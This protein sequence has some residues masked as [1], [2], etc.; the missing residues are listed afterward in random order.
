[1]EKLFLFQKFSFTL[2]P[3]NAQ[4]N[5]RFKEDEQG[6]MRCSKAKKQFA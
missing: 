6:L 4:E 1:M 5:D 2:Q 3:E